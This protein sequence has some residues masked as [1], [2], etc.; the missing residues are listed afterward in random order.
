MRFSRAGVPRLAINVVRAADWG[1]PTPALA[2]AIAARENFEKTARFFRKPFFD[3][4]VR[5]DE[6]HSFPARGYA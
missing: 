1:A 4:A 5:A 3:T 2:V 6:Y